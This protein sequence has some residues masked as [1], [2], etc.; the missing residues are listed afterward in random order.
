MESHV[1][2][3]AHAYAA[4]HESTGFSPLFLM[5]RRHPRLAI[6]AFLGS[7]ASERKNCHQ[8]CADRL[9]ER[10]QNAYRRAGKDALR[11]RKKAKKYYDQ[12]VKHSSIPPGDQMLV[13]TVGIQGKH[14]LADVWE[15]NIY[16]V[17][18]QPMSDIPVCE[19]KQENAN[20][21][22]R[23]LYQNMLLSF[24]GLP[25]IEESDSES[26]RE[27]PQRNAPE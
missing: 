9:Q 26:V 17:T 22:P 18:S 23:L 12:N 14:K 1:K 8:D 13:K 19:V 5:L 10:L 3:L 7:T 25:V 21:K 6:D 27:R 20:F 4:V 24:K 11:K 15:T 16:I 2:T